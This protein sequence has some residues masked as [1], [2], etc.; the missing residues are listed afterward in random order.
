MKFKMTDKRLDDINSLL[1]THGDSL[2]TFYDEGICYGKRNGIIIG[3]LVGTVVSNLWWITRTFK[4]HK[5]SET[6]S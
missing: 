1:K 4:N 5:K 3:A 2:T 6:E